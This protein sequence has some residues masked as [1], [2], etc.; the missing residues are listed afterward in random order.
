M[1]AKNDAGAIMTTID[2]SSRPHLGFIGLGGMGSR[3]AG[4]LLAAGYDL[5]V[6]NR[7]RERTRSLEQ[8]GARVAG[9]PRELA[10]CADIILSSLADDEAVESVMMGPEGALAAARPGTV[11]IEMSTVSPETPRKLYEEAGRKGVQFLDAPVSG[12]APQAEQAQLVIFVGGEE[13][14]YN[15]CRSVLGVLGKV[16]IYLGPS[17][18][19]ATMK[20]CVNA[21][22]G[23]GMQALAEAIAFGLKAGL[24]RERLLAALAQTAVVSDSQKSKL[25]NARTNAYP[26]TF[27]LRLMYKDFGLIMNRAMQLSVPMPV[28]AAAQ[29]VCAIEHGHQSATGRD[30][31]F[32]SVIRAMAQM[33]GIQQ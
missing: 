32:S 6:Y 1:S 3:M 18:S 26:A 22:L 12:S 24:D 7:N 25:E 11:F 2:Q 10:P 29:Q 13:A 21:L 8:R 30:E 23:L 19:G 15:Q 17:G 4:R 33:A 31:D 5:T 9:T 14:V 20:L 27:P 28:A 16:S